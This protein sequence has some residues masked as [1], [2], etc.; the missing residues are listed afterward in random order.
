M[1][2]NSIVSEWSSE[3]S[4]GQGPAGITPH[5]LVMTATPIPRTVALTVY[6]DLETRHCV[7]FRVAASRS[8]RPRFSSMTSRHGW[9][10]LAA[11]I[12]EVSA[13]RQPMW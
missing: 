10:V 12:E 11:I 2:T 9:T 4:C 7:N 8:L 1:S 5:L 13:G 3:I 6:G